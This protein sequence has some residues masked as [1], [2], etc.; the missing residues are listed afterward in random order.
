MYGFAGVGD[1]TS[2]DQ[3]NSLIRNEARM[4]PEISVTLGPLGRRQYA[5]Y[6]LDGRAVFYTAGGRQFG[7]QRARRVRMTQ[8]VRQLNCQRYQIFIK[9]NIW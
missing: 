8:R 9:R 3:I 2:L 7:F 1:D 4:K 5:W 6:M